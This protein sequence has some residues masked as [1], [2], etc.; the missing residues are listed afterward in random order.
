[1][2]SLSSGNTKYKEKHKMR[3]KIF[4]LEDDIALNE[5]ICDFLNENGFET[6]SAIDAE[7]AQNIIYEQKFDLLILDVNVPKLN[8]FE[9]LKKLRKNSN[10]TPAIFITSLNGVDDLE[11]GYRSGCDDYL[12]KP[13]ALKELLLRAETL[14]KRE[15]L[16]IN[17]KVKITKQCSFDI[18]SQLLYCNDEV[19]NLHS[20]EA[21]LLT[22]FLKNSNSIITHEMIESALWD[23]NEMSNTDSVRTYI[24]NLRKFL[25]KETIVSFKKLGYQLKQE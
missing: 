11:E 2:I 8:G 17:E 22:L 7:K 18:N 16:H 4:L 10:K 13:F 25:G 24:K 20:K 3:A 1:M 15:F 21:K 5:T 19:I 12:K 23:F 14:L 6:A 9:L